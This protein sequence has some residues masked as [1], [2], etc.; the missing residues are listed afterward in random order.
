MATKKKSSKKPA[1]KIS[2]SPAKKTSSKKKQAAPSPKHT[3]K[4]H[5]PLRSSFSH[6]QPI[7]VAING[8]GRIGRM[9]FCAALNNPRIK[10]VAINDLTPAST[11]AKTLLLTNLKPFPKSN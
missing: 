6:G 8:F 7:R 11:L 9:V 10:I 1:K 5:A 4:E 2:K 3:P